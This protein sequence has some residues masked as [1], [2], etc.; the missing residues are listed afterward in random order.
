MFLYGF[1]VLFELKDETMWEDGCW[2]TAGNL[3]ISCGHL[4]G[5]IDLRSWS[6]RLRVHSMIIIH[7][8]TPY[9]TQL[10]HRIMGV[11]IIL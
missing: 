11:S 5:H 1:A 2:R 10:E 7:I 4:T 3:F 8:N 9:T 6:S